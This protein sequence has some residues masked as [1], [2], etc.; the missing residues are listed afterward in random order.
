MVGAAIVSIEA[1]PR[2]RHLGL[3]Q[4]RQPSV[5]DDGAHD[6]R[7]A[8]CEGGAGTSPCGEGG[9][10]VAAAL[11]AELHEAVVDLEGVGVGVWVGVGVGVR[12]GVRVRVRVRARA[13]ARVRARVGRGRSRPATPWRCP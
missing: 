10:A 4:L 6:E 7:V 1:Q 9:V 12:V 2:A 8:V 13:R 11:T 5:G 3:A